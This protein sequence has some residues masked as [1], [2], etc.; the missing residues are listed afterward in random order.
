[1]KIRDLA[2]EAVVISEESTFRDALSLM[3]SKQTNSLLVVNE[4]GVLTGEVGVSDLLNATVPDFLAPE[5]VL[6]ELS[7]EEGFGKAVL[8]AAEKPVK[9]FMTIDIQPIHVDDSLLAIA[10]TAIAHGA[11]HIP[12]VDQ[13]ERPIGV[14]SR[15][16]LKH[17]LAQYLGIKDT[18]D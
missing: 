17:I 6:E 8:G 15:R 10:G 7:T 11:Q 5:K 2:K 12:I 3:V 16:G 14:I 1:M 18:E 9:D 13:D 4:D